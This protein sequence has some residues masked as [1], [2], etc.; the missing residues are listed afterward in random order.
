MTYTDH[1]VALGRDRVVLLPRDPEGGYVYWELTAEGLSQAGAPSGPRLRILIVA[2][3]D[4]GETIAEQFAIESWLDGRF[5]NFHGE[6]IEYVARLG[7]DI[8]GEF[9]PVAT[10]HSIRSPRS[11]AGDDEPEF[12]S[13][14]MG[15]GG[16]TLTPTEHEHP[17]LGTFKA[18][19]VDLPSSRS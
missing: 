5:I 7:V 18:A 6:D 2:R 13:V 17:E 4:D 1:L 10:S 14:E 12:V 15:E 16:L 9:V 3:T 19:S 11:R 8:D